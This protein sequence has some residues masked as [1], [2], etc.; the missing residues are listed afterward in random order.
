VQQQISVVVH[1]VPATPDAP[2]TAQMQVLALDGT[3]LESWDPVT[4]AQATTLEYSPACVDCQLEGV[5]S[6]TPAA[7]PAPAAKAPAAAA[8]AK[9]PAPSGHAAPPRP[10]GK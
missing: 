3:V 7:P 10:Q 4:T 6:S 2:A 9:A 8:P 1:L 5:Y